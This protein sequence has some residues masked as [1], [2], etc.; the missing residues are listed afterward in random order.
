MGI[1]YTKRHIVD[2]NVPIFGAMNKTQPDVCELLQTY[3]DLNDTGK[4]EAIKR[5]QELADLSQYKRAK[6]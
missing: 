5:I 1:P 2:E 6:K 4:A 3:D